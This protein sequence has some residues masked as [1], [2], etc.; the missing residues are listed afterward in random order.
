MKQNLA[1]RLLPWLFF[2]VLLKS[3]MQWNEI[4]KYVCNVIT[5]QTWFYIFFF[6]L[7][8]ALLIIN[9]IL[10]E[11]RKWKYNNKN[12]SYHDRS[13]QTFINFYILPWRIFKS[14]C[15]NPILIII[16]FLV[17]CYLSHFFWDRVLPVK[18]FQYWLNINKSVGKLFFVYERVENNI[19]P[20]HVCHAVENMFDFWRSRGYKD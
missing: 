5:Q 8:L 3:F 1:F 12:H 19:V 13:H 17:Y 16:F 6:P 2:S 9:N 15:S 20:L 10:P 18:I 11:A 7:F 4:F 14:Y